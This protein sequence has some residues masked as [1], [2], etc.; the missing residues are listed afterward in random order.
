MNNCRSTALHNVRA[1]ASIVFSNLGLPGN[2]WDL[3]SGSKRKESLLFQK[4]LIFGGENRP[5]PLIPLY[6][7]DL[8][9]NDR[10]LF[11]VEYLPIV[12]YLF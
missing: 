5:K 6:Y 4:L 3:S 8:K 7:P 10:F 11:M 2:L 9:K 1:S 12:R